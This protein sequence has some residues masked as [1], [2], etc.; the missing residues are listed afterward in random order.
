MGP[1]PCAIC[2]SKKMT[3]A[4]DTHSPRHFCRRGE[5]TL[6]QTE[7]MLEF[8]LNMRPS[9]SNNEQNEGEIPSR[10]GLEWKST[11][12]NTMG[13]PFAFGPGTGF[14]LP[15]AILHSS[16]SECSRR[17]RRRSWCGRCI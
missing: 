13:G 14:E 3:C 16:G 4:D 2:P 10:L 7:F 12:A 8:P 1:H 11:G 17:R 5:I 15:G 9:H 6:Q